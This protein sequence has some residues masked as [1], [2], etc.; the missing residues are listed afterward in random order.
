MTMI[1]NHAGDTVYSVPNECHSPNI[2]THFIFSTEKSVSKVREAYGNWT[3]NCL[4]E[5]WFSQ[6]C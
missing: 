5:V 1:I 2:C 4:R 3:T 6:Q